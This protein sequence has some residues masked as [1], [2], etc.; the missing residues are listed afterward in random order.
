MT[1]DSPA[2]VPAPQHKPDI[3]SRIMRF[4]PLYV[5]VFCVG[6]VVLVG[7]VRPFDSPAPALTLRD[8]L[9]GV[10]YDPTGAYMVIHNAGGADTL[11]SASTPAAAS[12]QLQLFAPVDT[13]TSVVA[14]GG[15]VATI[16]GLLTDV[17]Q[18][19]IPGFGDLRLQPGTAQ[20][21]LK[22][23]VSPLTVGQQISITLQFKKAGA[24]TVD[25]TVAT[26]DDI[27]DRL[28]P[29]RLKLPGQ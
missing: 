16:G 27:A 29:P 12:V 4:A 10:D 19:D 26:Y 22:G 24:I 13:T 23:L 9:V 25:A 18:L 28:L 21:L 15:V 20:L 2:D 14:S 1:T 3:Y 8:P 11:L 17:D 5:I 6:I 7:F